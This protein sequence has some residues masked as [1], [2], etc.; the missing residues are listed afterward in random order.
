MRQCLGCNGLVPESSSSCPNC[1]VTAK[2]HGL[3][4]KVVVATGTLAL[5]ACGIAPAPAYGVPCASKQVDGGTNGCIGECTTL[6]SDGG[7]PR[8]N[9]ADTACFTD[10]GTP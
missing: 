8:K 6:Q 9:P 3:V 7:D 1:E 2:K 10:G 4:R 5:I